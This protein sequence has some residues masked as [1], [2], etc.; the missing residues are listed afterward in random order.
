MS[1]TYVVDIP[2]HYA[3]VFSSIYDRK[4]NYVIVGSMTI[5]Y[6]PSTPDSP[7]WIISPWPGEQ[8]TRVV[9]CNNGSPEIPEGEF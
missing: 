8:I 4:L 7:Q 1:R 5:V 6:F 9:S 2:G 3:L